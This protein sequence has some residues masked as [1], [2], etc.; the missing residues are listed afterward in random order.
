[1]KTID[2]Q[3]K[4]VPAVFENLLKKTEQSQKKLQAMQL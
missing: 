1:M 4:P 2:A 3:P